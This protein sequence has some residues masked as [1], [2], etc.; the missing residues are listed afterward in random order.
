[1]ASPSV[2]NEGPL[3]LAMY[4]FAMP[5]CVY[6]LSDRPMSSLEVGEDVIV[7]AAPI[8]ADNEN[9]GSSVVKVSPIGSPDTQLKLFTTFA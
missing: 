2:T 5:C 7:Y 9:L 6:P 1:M 3:E 4:L 8:S